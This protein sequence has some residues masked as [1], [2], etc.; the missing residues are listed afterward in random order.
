ML[1]L[2][3]IGKKPIPLP[4]GVNLKIDGTLVKVKGP[5]GELSQEIPVETKVRQEKEQVIVERSND[6]KHCKSMHGLVRTLVANMVEGVNT[7]FTKTL[8]I[9]GVGYRAAM[10]GKK[11]VLNVGY[12]Q[13]VE[14]EPFS[15]IEIEVP[16]PNKIIVQG[17]DKQKVGEMAAM[18]R[19]VRKPEPYKGK[20]IRYENEYV[21]R[22]AG[23]AGKAG[24]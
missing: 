14:I 1:I 3:R 9:H 2:S 10:Q 7:G 4:A 24:K 19:G 20:G 5:K 22:K 13:P 12:S 18:I 15:G 23:K 8:E 17:I 6:T 11:L 16:A 21:R